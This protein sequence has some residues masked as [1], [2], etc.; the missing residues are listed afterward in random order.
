MNY[1]NG[2]VAVEGDPVIGT[3]DTG[4]VVAGTLHLTTVDSSH[5]IY[6]Q[7]AYPTV[8]GMKVALVNMAGIYHAQDALASVIVYQPPVPHAV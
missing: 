5:G 7:V 1:A 2:R 6:A 4:D 8:V 3:L